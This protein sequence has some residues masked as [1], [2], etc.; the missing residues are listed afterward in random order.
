MG[1]N[2]MKQYILIFSIL[3]FSA[4]SNLEQGQDVEKAFLDFPQSFDSLYESFENDKVFFLNNIVESQDAMTQFY[5]S[6]FFQNVEI[7][8][9]EKIS[10]TDFVVKDINDKEYTIN[11][12][13]ENYKITYFRVE[14]VIA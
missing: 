9:V 14:E 3:F 1:V 13:V 6:Q 7:K 12:V 5:C 10:D 2:V 8:S 11:I 4:C